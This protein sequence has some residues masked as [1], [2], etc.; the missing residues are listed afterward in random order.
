MFFFSVDHD[1]LVVIHPGK[2][3]AYNHIVRPKSAHVYM[4]NVVCH[5]LRA[6]NH[7]IFSPSSSSS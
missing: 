4:L 1:D 3:N 7:D 5:R 2:S 6:L